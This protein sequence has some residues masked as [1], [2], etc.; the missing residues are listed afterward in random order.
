M[1]KNYLDNIRW[2]TVVVVVLY[3]VVYMYNGEGIP[4]VLGKITSLDVQYQDLFQYIVYPWI[5]M[6]LFMVSGISSRLYLEKHSNREFIRSRTRKLLV[7]STIGLVAFQFLQGYVNISLS[8]PRGVFLGHPEI[9]LAVKIVVLLLSGIGVLW[10][11]QLLWLFSLLLVLVRSIEKDR[12][13][14]AGGKAG[15][16]VLIGLLLPTFAA[17]QILNTPIVVVYRFGLYFFVFLL[18]YFVLSHDEPVACLKKHFPIFLGAA[19]A[20]G[21]AFCIRYF[22]KNYADNPIYRSPL[23]ISYG[24]AASLAIMGSPLTV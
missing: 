23:F 21:T 3:H 16:P 20:L 15:L 4:G 18:G 13:W 7:P 14:K 22:G 19:L 10:Y 5:M 17:A 1:R 24:Y 12:L 6:L 11:I 2:M 9:P 8:T